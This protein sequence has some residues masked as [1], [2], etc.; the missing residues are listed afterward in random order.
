MQTEW[1]DADYDAIAIE[2]VA[3]LRRSPMLRRTVVSEDA[4]RRAAP[5]TLSVERVVGRI[6]TELRSSQ[7]FQ[8]F[9]EVRSEEFDVAIVGSVIAAELLPLRFFDVN[10]G[11]ASY[12]QWQAVARRVAR[13]MRVPRCVLWP[14][15]NVTRGLTDW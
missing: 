13:E 6:V 14:S 12:T 1:S 2:V 10:C 7:G 4:T 8:S 9:G 11:A 15:L 5:P 3:Q